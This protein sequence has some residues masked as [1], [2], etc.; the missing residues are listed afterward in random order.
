M[1]WA[2]GGPGGEPELR[3]GVHGNGRQHACWAQVQHGTL[4]QGL[5][6]LLTAGLDPLQRLSPARVVVLEVLALLKGG[7]AECRKS[8]QMAGA[9]SCA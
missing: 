2:I 8:G 6:R 1:G 3:C 4:W 9:G 5:V 7:R